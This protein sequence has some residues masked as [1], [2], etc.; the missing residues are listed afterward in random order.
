M[1]ALHS[2]EAL[3]RSTHNAYDA[4]RFDEIRYASRKINIAANVY[5]STFVYMA[6]LQP[7]PKS[8]TVKFGS[9]LFADR[10]YLFLSFLLDNILCRAY[11][12]FCDFYL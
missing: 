3:N 1:F 4:S 6:N 9:L 5:F 7:I 10:N 11:T 2:I 12:R 8:T